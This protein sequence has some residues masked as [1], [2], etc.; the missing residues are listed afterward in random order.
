LKKNVEAADVA[1]VLA[2]L[3]ELPISTWSYLTEPP[4]VRHLGPMAQDFH[5]RFGLGDDD[6][7]YQAVDGHG[8]ALAALQAL[9]RL[10]EEQARRIAVLERKNRDLAHGLRALEQKNGQDAKN[11]AASRPAPAPSPKEAPNPSR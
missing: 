9:D 2:R 11:G 4:G 8:V 10:V 1:G 3:R 7:T 6:R 5:A